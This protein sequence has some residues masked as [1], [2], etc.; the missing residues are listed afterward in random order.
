ML[1][2]IAPIAV[3][4]TIALAAC[5]P[6]LMAEPLPEI[7]VAQVDPDAID[8][9][10]AILGLQ[11][12]EKVWEHIPWLQDVEKAKAASQESGRPVFLFSMWGELDGRC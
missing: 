4:G 6:Y 8:A 7:S 3:A 9:Q 1:K 5:H 12:K 11:P 10:V 2:L